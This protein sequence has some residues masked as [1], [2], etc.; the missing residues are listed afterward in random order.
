[1]PSFESLF[2]ESKGKPI[3]YKGQELR[4][5]DFVPFAQGDRVRV[6]FERRS[7][8]WRQGVGL[9][10]PGAFEV[11]GQEI[12]APIVLWED[13]APTET[14]IRIL[15]PAGQLEVKN[16]WDTGNGVIHSW[17][18]GAAMIIEEL[19]VGG[20]RYRCNDGHPDD[21]FDDIVFRLEKLKD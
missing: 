9:K 21:N 16:V 18:N 12:K 14:E 4:L 10:V 19:P 13:T 3:V 5:V 7:S 8:E 6:T 17:H 1:M 2:K 11:A 15:A 20:R